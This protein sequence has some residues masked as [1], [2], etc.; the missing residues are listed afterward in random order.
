MMNPQEVS[1]RV[2]AYRGN[3]QALM[4]KYAM[5]QDLLDLLALQQLKK[6]KDDIARQMTL[7]MG[8]EQGKPP[9][10]AEQLGKETFDMTRQ[11][12]A[13]KLGMQP[14]QQSGG[15]EGGGGQGMPPQGMPPQGMPQQ[16]PMGQ[17][18]AAN[19]APNMSPQA[20]ASGGIV[21]FAEGGGTK[22]KLDRQRE[23]DRKLAA[24]VARALKSGAGKF[25][26]AALDVATLPT[27]AAAG[28]VDTA[29]IRPVRAM[30]ADLPYISSKFVPEG[31]DPETMTPF[32]DRLRMQDAP[33]ADN[34]GAEN[35]TALNRAEAAAA[36]R[37]SYTGTRLSPGQ[38]MELARRAAASPSSEIAQV[39]VDYKTRFPDAGTRSVEQPP[40]QTFGGGSGSGGGYGSQ[41]TQASQPRPPS[42]PS[43]LEALLEEQIR[44]GV[45]AKPDYSDADAYEQNIT[46]PKQGIA[47][48]RQAALQERQA[49]AA[50]LR[51][52][53]LGA[54]KDSRP[55]WQQKLAAM[56]AA[57]DP[58]GGRL[59]G[60]RAIGQGASDF[61][62]QRKAQEAEKVKL[63]QLYQAQI[64]KYQ[65]AG[66]SLQEAEILAQKD[67]M[68]ERAKAR[69]A[70]EVRRKD[71]VGEL[72]EEVRSRRTDT[73]TQRGQDV[74]AE[75]WGQRIAAGGVGG[76]D[77]GY[78]RERMEQLKQMA[79]TIKTELA[80]KSLQ[81]MNPKRYQELMALQK[82]VQDALAAGIGLPV[83][84]GAAPAGNTADPLGIR[85]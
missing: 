21:G 28:V 61:E 82:Q 24:A 5:S 37:T 49:R 3:P 15:D 69:A 64:E 42:A 43:G 41:S 34:R 57:Y 32:M 2:D 33:E 53:A 84:S 44:S 52:Q 4:Q 60:L 77:G 6:E 79:A 73:T 59:G 83:Q 78:D 62:T 63:E 1:Q 50:E 81:I 7:Q 80:D 40:A 54:M 9:T 55:E 65:D 66:F 13:Q 58:K 39:W 23:E 12:M 20:M 74:T 10:V 71:A 68:D 70:A 48:Q 11:D 56:A 22:E 31:V 29:L 76:A 30:G 16:N 8:Q 26:A 36:E 19:P 46:K 18:I 14:P 51:D 35:R 47:A 85:R 27:R 45:A 38:E 17:G 72:G 25:S 67:L 75:T